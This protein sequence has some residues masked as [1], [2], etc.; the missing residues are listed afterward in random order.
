M[1]I[2]GLGL[3]QYKRYDPKVSSKGLIYIIVYIKCIKET[4]KC[5][6]RNFN[7]FINDSQRHK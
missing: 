5:Q 6:L 1:S 4:K 7:E 3:D 2:S